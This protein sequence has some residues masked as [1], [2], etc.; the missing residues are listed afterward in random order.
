MTTRLN[1]DPSLLKPLLDKARNDLQDLKSAQFAGADNLIF[2]INASGASYDA[3]QTVAAF[4]SALFFC[5]FTPTNQQYALADLAYE[6][7]YDAVDDSHKLYPM[8]EWGNGT[9]FIGEYPVNNEINL[10]QSRWRF[11]IQNRD[12]VSHT[13]YI[14]YYV[15]STDV[16]TIALTP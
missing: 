9:Y 14:K 16:G 8:K 13:F 6:L 1:Q 12:S 15:Q 7:W 10:V 3:S 5:G 4:S 2:K 11:F